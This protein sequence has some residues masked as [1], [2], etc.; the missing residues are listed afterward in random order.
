MDMVVDIN[1]DCSDLPKVD[2][3]KSRNAHFILFKGNDNISMGIRH[4]NGHDVDVEQV[5][6]LVLDNSPDGIVLDIGANLGSFSVPLAIDYPKFNFFGF[7]PQ[8]VIYYQF[9]G[10]III[11]SLK[12]INAYNFG[13]GDESFCS[14]FNIPN[15]KTERII[16]GFSIDEEI[17]SNGYECASVGGSQLINV[18]TL[19][20]LNID[21]I[22][23][24]KI[25]VEGFELQVL[26]G[27][28]QTLKNSGYPPIL[29]EA[30]DWKFHERRAELIEFI[31]SLG[32]NISSFGNNHLAQYAILSSDV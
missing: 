30:W 15:Y 20:S 26:K 28:L 3:V 19:D 24:V 25:D 17:R 12:N 7:E 1:I 11:N 10:N 18:V 31:E 27:S 4:H 22:R 14:S 23:L 2:I 9:C 6:R 13:L 5:A 29:F 16:G 21:N 32:Y 8:R